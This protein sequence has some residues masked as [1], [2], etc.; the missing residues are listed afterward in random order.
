MCVFEC[1]EHSLNLPLAP[2]YPPGCSQ[3]RSGCRA[4][5]FYCKSQADDLKAP[6]SP[7]LT[8]C[9]P[10][11]R[12]FGRLWRLHGCTHVAGTNQ[13]TNLPTNP[14]T[15]RPPTDD[16]PTYLPAYIYIQSFACVDAHCRPRH[17]FLRG[18]CRMLALSCVDQ[19]YGVVS[20]DVRGREHL[21]PKQWSF[22]V[23]S[24]TCF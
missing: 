15:D 5:S 8:P 22:R 19:Y 16:G 24:S 6:P 7:S 2:D 3:R 21:Q 10:V 23:L 4:G 17:T 12:C 1:C 20:S 18:S 14:P 11:E 9:G 13:P